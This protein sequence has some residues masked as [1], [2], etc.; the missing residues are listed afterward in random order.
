MLSNE[1]LTLSVSHTSTGQGA[2][3]CDSACHFSPSLAFLLSQESLLSF[4]VG[5]PSTHSQHALALPGSLPS[6]KGRSW[7]SSHRHVLLSLGRFFSQGLCPSQVRSHGLPKGFCLKVMNPPETLYGVCF[8]CKPHSLGLF[9]SYRDQGQA[10]VRQK[11]FT[12]F[13]V[14]SC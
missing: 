5:N 8:Y 6:W 10:E 12:F 11:Y 13:A 14:P 3:T 2:D 1:N 4:S 7:F 9:L